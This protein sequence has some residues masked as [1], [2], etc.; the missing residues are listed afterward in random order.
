MTDRPP[1]VRQAILLTGGLS[2]V[3]LLGL[4]LL[5]PFPA[6][7]ELDLGLAVT[8]AAASLGLCALLTRW[9]PLEA[10]FPPLASL[11][12]LA[13]SGI[14]YL[15]R[16]LLEEVYLLYLLAIIAAAILWGLRQSVAV[17]IG[18]SLTF[19]LVLLAQPPWGWGDAA[20]FI[21][22]T[23]TFLLVSL[24]VGAIA[25]SERSSREAGAGMGRALERERMLSALTQ[26]DLTLASTLNPE[27]LHEEVCRR[28]AKLLGAHGAYL[29]LLEGKE[30]VGAA[31]IGP[32]AESFPGRRQAGG[33][34]GGLAGRAVASGDPLHWQ[35]VGGQTEAESDEQAG[36]PGAKSGLAVPLR[37][38][39]ELLGALEL[40]DL[41]DPHRFE[42]V[43]LEWARILGLQAGLAIH[44][45]RRYQVAMRSNA[46]LTALM[47]TAS[48]LS[49]SLDLHRVLAAAREV[50]AEV[51]EVAQATI[52]L[53]EPDGE[54][55]R[56]SAERLTPGSPASLGTRMPLEGMPIAEQVLR[57]REPL[58]IADVLSEPLP[59]G[60]REPLESRNVRSAL[61][62]PLICRGQVL[63]VASLE[64]AQK[65][66]WSPEDVELAQAIAN[67]VATALEN[68]RLYEEKQA[69]LA[70]VAALS[71]VSEALNRHLELPEILRRVLTES[72][73]LVHTEHGGLLLVDADN[74]SLRI[75]VSEGLSSREVEAI[76][77]RRPP[78]HGGVFGVSLA[79][80]EF[81]EISEPSDPR[82]AQLPGMPPGRLLV[83]PLRT[84]SASLGVILLAGV[85]RVPD[86]ATRFL[87]AA[88]AD[89]A[90]VA[91][92]RAKLFEEARQRARELE[93]LYET[94]QAISSSL[95]LRQVLETI[96]RQARN[97]LKADASRIYLLRAEEGELEPL[98]ALEEGAELVLS[99]P[100][101]VGEGITGH[102]AR[103]GVGEVVNRAHL[104][105]RG[106][107]IPGTPLEPDNLLCVPLK[108]GEEVI[109]V[110]TLTRFGVERDFS[111][112]DLRAAT[113]LASQA[114]LSIRNAQLYEETI[115][116]AIT[117][118]VTG[119]YNR[120]Y[121]M[122]ELE[123]EIARAGRYQ[124][125]FSVVMADIDSFKAFNDRY[126][127]LVGD[128]VLRH[129]AQLMRD[130][131]RESD[132]VARYGG[133]EFV[134]ILPETAR[135]GGLALIQKLQHRLEEHPFVPG[136]G[137]TP[138]H[139]QVSF[140]LAVYPDDGF[141]AE[142]LIR[143]ADEAMY[144]LKRARSSPP[145]D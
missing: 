93:A 78:A 35:A 32:G 70:Q 138:V 71:R 86:A 85:A 107:H 103:T 128:T 137:R 58:A 14:V 64:A 131:L 101:K 95:E 17:A 65:R 111:E 61:V 100:L 116:L 41:E 8:L 27:E 11:A 99:L 7:M 112:A 123:R 122:R 132:I 13:I 54:V 76:N 36:S 142:A 73:K 106:K 119:I 10:L 29:W 53:L 43:D 60:G 84:E 23:S 42:A 51:F 94:S 80:G 136:D 74:R 22:A 49:G 52:A 127:H 87:L 3:L 108:V 124:R 47:R 144:A 130:F 16:P 69:Q 140:G 62:V 68:A 115:Q 5:A 12:L 75:E 37:A 48:A 9:R 121:L 33:S 96:A 113:A 135:E 129:L 104:D 109:G 59:E 141:E 30:L 28:S 38:G 56:L 88:L 102:V 139:L 20:Q 50:L 19:G 67:Q 120:R 134:L 21:L 46:E 145:G 110:M 24:V 55:L 72:L 97:L 114:A 143:A 34:D 31:A 45:A 126:G 39:S 57:T 6:G 98:V 44:N 25:Q 81:I 133:E 82:V 26:V 79:T 117:D 105:P 118:S 15:L 66:S 4:L 125:P 63:G 92:Q 83:I 89:I 77:D 90:A 1:P 40:L 2:A 18:S 91:I